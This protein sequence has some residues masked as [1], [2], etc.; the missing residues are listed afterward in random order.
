MNKHKV[1]H[2]ICDCRKQ[3]R[4]RVDVDCILHALGR[5]INRDERERMV[6]TL[7]EDYK[8]YVDNVKRDGS[9]RVKKR[10]LKENEQQEQKH[11]R[12]VE[13]VWKTILV[14]IIVI[15]AVLGGLLSFAWGRKL[16]G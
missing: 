8:D 6:K 10:A 12:Q 7:R 1:I 9:M 4:G 3:H 16:F 2:A 11:K 15:L 13:L 5:Q 14:A